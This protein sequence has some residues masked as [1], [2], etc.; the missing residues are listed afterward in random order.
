[1]QYGKIWLDFN[2]YNGIMKMNNKHGRVNMFE[3]IGSKLKMLAKVN[4]WVGIS[5][6]I[7]AA[8]VMFASAA[9][10]FYGGEMYIAIGFAVLIIG[11]LFSWI[12]SFVIYGF[13]ELI[14]KT[15]A[16]ERS[17]VDNSMSETFIQLNSER[18]A[19]L[20]N[21]R[22]KNL[23]TEDEYQKIINKEEI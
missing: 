12:G 18:I 7:I 23:I 22:A 9:D 8:I 3:N 15:C 10:S 2:Y 16:I 17:V 21:L 13:G 20:N 11:P 14:D 19:K 5:L 1:M 4:C 6:S